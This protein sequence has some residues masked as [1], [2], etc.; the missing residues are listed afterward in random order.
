MVEGTILRV[1]TYIAAAAARRLESG[2]ESALDILEAVVS[3]ADES[4][5]HTPELLPVLKEAGV[6]D[7][8]GKGLFFLL[9]GMLRMTHGLSLDQPLA[10]VQP[11]SALALESAGESIEPGQD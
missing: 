10:T 11:L 7:S 9:E 6:V 1:S 3:A 5:E 8:G 4:V 2:A